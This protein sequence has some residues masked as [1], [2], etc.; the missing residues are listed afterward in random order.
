MLGESPPRC[1]QRNNGEQHRIKWRADTERF[2]LGA[3]LALNLRARGARGERDLRKEKGRARVWHESR[4]PEAFRHSRAVGRLGLHACIARSLPTAGTFK[5]PADPPASPAMP[6]Q[7]P[8]KS[9]PPLPP[10]RLTARGAGGDTLFIL[11][12]KKERSVAPALPVENPPLHTTPP[13]GGSTPDP[14]LAQNAKG[15]Q[16]PMKSG[17][18]CAR[19]ARR[20]G[21]E[22]RD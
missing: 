19:A 6:D 10:L 16:G 2:A 7:N 1:R 5:R 14:L 13:Q 12:Q 22:E 4:G 15:L 18:T 17:T 9:L 11:L 8:R 20:D 3:G 21:E